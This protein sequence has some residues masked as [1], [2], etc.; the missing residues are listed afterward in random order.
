MLSR[1]ITLGT[2]EGYQEERSIAEL[3]QRQVVPHAAE[4]A[5]VSRQWPN[6]LRAEERNGPGFARS[7]QRGR[8]IE[9]V[10]EWLEH[11]AGL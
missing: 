4:Y 2:D 11:T 6:W 3:R 1:H 5:V 8:R 7:Q 9:H 10:L